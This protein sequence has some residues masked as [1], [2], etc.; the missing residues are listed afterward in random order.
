MSK[1]VCVYSSSSM[2]VSDEFKELA[3]E[4]GRE[5]GRRGWNLI[6]GAGQHGLMG[7]TARGVHESGGTVIGVIPEKMD[8]PEITYMEADVLITTQDLRERK[9]VMDSKADGFIALPGGIGT[10]EEII[11]ML[12]LR[13][14]GFHE[15]PVIFLNSNGY[16]NP[17]FD[18]FD[19]MIEHNT[20]SHKHKAMYE[21]STNPKMALDI[22][23]T[24]SND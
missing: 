11:E 24:H 21:V 9:G 12:T 18:F 5:I 1:S 17:L 15:R 3:S 14:L 10:L 7:A 16:Y 8:H 19:H 13:Q 23:A 2:I 20:Y 4:L 6:F 22:I